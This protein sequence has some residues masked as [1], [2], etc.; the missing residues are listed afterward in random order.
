M[1]ATKVLTSVEDRDYKAQSWV[2]TADRILVDHIK[3]QILKWA[4][5]IENEQGPSP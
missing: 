2:E 5:H 1:N 4:R 3:I